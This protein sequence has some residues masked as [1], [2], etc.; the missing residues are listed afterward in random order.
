MSDWREA[1]QRR[2]TEGR[3]T[4][5]PQ[6]PDAVPSADA[7]ATTYVPEG[8]DAVPWHEIIDVRVTDSLM[9][10]I[11]Y[12]TGNLMLAATDFEV[13][14]VGQNLRLART[15]NSLDA[16]WGQVS[17]R[18]WQEY[19]RYLLVQQDAAGT[20]EDPRDGLVGL[21]PSPRRGAPHRP[22]H[23]ESSGLADG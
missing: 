16:P 12:S 2:A 4:K 9:V 17:Q 8:Q 15:Y 1:Q 22:G 10:R 20:G 3:G 6:G 19:E 18:W 21:P 11:N 5:E 14:G 13:A 7:A 23:R